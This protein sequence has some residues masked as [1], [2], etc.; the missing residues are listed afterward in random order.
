MWV[1]V[2]NATHKDYP[3]EESPPPQDAQLVEVCRK[4]GL[5]A[6]DGCY[7]KVPD[8]EHG[9]VKLVRDT[10]IEVLR[11]RSYFDQYCNLHGSGGAPISV[12]SVEEPQTPASPTVPNAEPVHM[13]GLTVI[14]TDPYN[15]V[16]PV[17]KAEPVNA[18]GSAIKKAI[19]V[20]DESQKLA[21]PVIK[22]EPPPPLKLDK[23]DK[24]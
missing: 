13:K 19:P 4:S 10:Y 18:D 20:E 2:M 24:L 8:A 14:G 16:V 15:A 17:L 5:R 23:L 9:G 6:T 11:R 21:K 12:I 3:A 1:D 22:L 7:E